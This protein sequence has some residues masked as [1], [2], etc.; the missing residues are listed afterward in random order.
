MNRLLLIL[1]VCCVA[2]PVVQAAD[3][4]PAGEPLPG[5]AALDWTG[6]IASRLV[7]GAD[8]F[9]LR[10]LERSIGRR[11][12]HWHRDYSSPE[13]YAASVEP[14]RQRL[15]HI[16]GLRDP[17]VP[18]DGLELAGTTRQPALVGRGPNY[19][20]FAVRWPAVSGRARRGPAAD[21]GAG[22]RRLS[23]TSSPCPTRTRRRRCWPG[24]CRA[25][26]PSRSTPGGWPRAAAACWCRC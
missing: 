11:E 21:A 7:D 19:Q 13:R 26:R 25:C 20:V 1:C 14:N 18:F 17:R 16:L 5:T 8:R 10:E 2:L 22:P 12:S 6:D 15:M 24:W 9:L 3:P 4:P 23:P